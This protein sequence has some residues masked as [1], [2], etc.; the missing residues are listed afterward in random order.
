MYPS[1][2]KIGPL[3]LHT[4]G[5]M[6]ALGLYGGLLIILHLLRKDPRRTPQIEESLYELFFIVILAGL[7]GARLYFVFTHWEF[8]SGNLVEIFKIWNG[9][10]VYYG[11]FIGGLIGSMVWFQRHPTISWK[12]W[13]DWIAPGLAFGEALGRL[14]CLSAGCCYGQTTDVPWGIIFTHAETLA[15]AYIR[16]HPTQIYEATFLMGLSGLLFWRSKKVGD[17]T[18]DLFAAP[19]QEA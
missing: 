11:G 4:Y 5:L 3:T 19:E 16:L 15:P 17:T 10:L 18:S 12:Q 13:L 9:G 2:F 1:L 6:V 8:Y 14:G 7:F